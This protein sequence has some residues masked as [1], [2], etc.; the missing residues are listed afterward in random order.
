MDDVIPRRAEEEVVS[1]RADQ[2]GAL[3]AAPDRRPK[4]KSPNVTPGA[5]RAGHPPL[6]RP[7]T[8]RGG[9]ADGIEG[10]TARDEGVS[11]GRPAVVGQRGVKDVRELHARAG[12]HIR[13]ARAE[14]LDPG[15]AVHAKQ[16]VVVGEDCASV[17]EELRCR[18]GRC[19]RR[20]ACR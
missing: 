6:V 11:L 1:R 4:L 2:G 12:H 19:C 10:R 7:R 16:V 15:G 3:P 13:G 17:V 9:G 5:V 20:P 14:A 8:A 18:W